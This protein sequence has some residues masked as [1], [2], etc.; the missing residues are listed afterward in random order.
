MLYFLDPENETA[1]FGINLLA[2]RNIASLK[3]RTDSYTRAYNVFYKLW[4]DQWG[5]WLQLILQNTLWA[6]IENQDY[7]LA[8][9]PMFLNPNNTAFRAHI[10][11]NIK[12]NKAVADFWNY[13]F[14]ARRERDQQERVDAALTRITTLLT[15]P[16]VRHIIGQQATTIDFP[17]IVGRQQ[18]LL[19]KLSANLSEDIKK[20]VGVILI[21]ELLH[22]VRNRPE[23]DRDQFCIFVDEFQNF[24]SSDDARTLITEGRKF[25]AAFTFAHQERFGQ[26][27]DQQKLMGATLAAANKVIF[28][29]TVIDAKELAPEFAQNAP[30]TRTRLG[31]QLVNSPHVIEDVWEKG[32]PLPDIMYTREKYFWIVDL[33]KQRPQGEVSLFDPQK[34]QVSQFNKGN[35]HYDRFYDWQGYRA[36][37]EMIRRGISLLNKHYFDYMQNRTQQAPITEYELGLFLEIIDCF[38]GIF[39]WRQTMEAHIPQHMRERF[40]FKIQAKQDSEILDMRRRMQQGLLPRQLMYH[41]RSRGYAYSQSEEGKNLE[42]DEII[43]RDRPDLL[44]KW[45]VAQVPNYYIKDWEIYEWTISGREVFHPTEMEEFIV[46]ERRETHSQERRVVTELVQLIADAPID[47]LVRWEANK[48]RVW[49]EYTTIMTYPLLVL[50]FGEKHNEL[51]FETKEPF[52]RLVAERIIW[53][54]TELQNFI[55]ECLRFFPWHIAQN[56]IQIQS[57]QYEEPVRDKTQSEMVDIMAQELTNLPQYSA[58]VKVIDEEDGHQSVYKGKIKTYP[59]DYAIEDMSEKG[60]RIE[61][62]KHMMNFRTGLAGLTKKR[63]AIEAEIRERQERWRRAQT[64]TTPQPPPASKPPPTSD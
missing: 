51:P 3:E 41:Y 40:I 32:H 23:N 58:Y 64:P 5:P 50:R 53:Q 18:K 29:S 60:K 28:Q 4:E 47:D 45:I 59:I 10:I 57:A 63:D 14:F 9:V 43:K 31:G 49:Q 6:F 25:G 27:A 46:W 42:V 55:I 36:T 21:S 8:D 56:P 1:S 19:V 33:L 44:K 17:D 35:L 30:D 61:S 37:A 20:F 26:F 13:E 22:A 48:H 15:H 52:M 12:H 7:T 34:I 54:L 11:D 24:A 2:C 39:G 62:C 16:Y 38:S